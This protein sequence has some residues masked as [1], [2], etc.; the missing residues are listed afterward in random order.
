M[1]EGTIDYY[2]RVVRGLGG[3]YK[4]TQEFARLLMAPGVDHCGGVRS[5]GPNPQNLFDYL[6]DW[7]E[8]GV[9]PDTI[10]S[11]QDLGGGLRWLRSMP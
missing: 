3:G 9:A 10:L 1:A 11:A 5:T 6:V 7:V 4:H 8:N 2:D